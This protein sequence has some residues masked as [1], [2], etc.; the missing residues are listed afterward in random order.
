MEKRNE[1]RTAAGIGAER[2]TQSPHIFVSRSLSGGVA[3]SNKVASAYTPA[4]HPLAF[5]LG[6]LLGT[7]HPPSFRP[8]VPASSVTVLLE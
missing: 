3:I 5:Q 1:R 8:D 2:P 4:G 6:I 7:R